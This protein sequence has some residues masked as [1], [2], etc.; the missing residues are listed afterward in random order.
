[1]VEALED[2]RK[3]FR[4]DPDALVADFHS[5]LVAFPAQADFNPAF[6][7]AEFDG[8]IEQGGKS[9][10]QVLAVSHDRR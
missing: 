8:I 4:L 3:D 5:N 10:L 9:T 1:M 6:V 7:W 2:M